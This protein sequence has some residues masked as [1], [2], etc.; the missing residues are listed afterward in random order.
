MSITRSWTYIDNN[1][2]EVDDETQDANTARLDALA[3]EWSQIQTEI[4]N[5][6][7]R[8]QARYEDGDCGPE[9]EEDCYPGHL[10][11]DCK[12][13]AKRISDRDATRQAKLEVIE[14]L[15][16][17]DGARMM[18]PY[19]H[20]NEDERYMEYMENRAEY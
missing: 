8:R 14:G 17:R 19:E 11:H 2:P 18:R 12:A 13:Q 6:G 3:R 10:C 5:E 1:S 15:L 9:C 4:E 7:F 20:W 16:A